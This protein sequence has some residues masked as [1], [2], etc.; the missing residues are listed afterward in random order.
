M[1]I[2]ITKV[3][4]ADG[5]LLPF[6]LA[7]AWATIDRVSGRSA[8]PSWSRGSAM[9]SLSTPTSPTAP[10]ARANGATGHSRARRLRS[11][12]VDPMRSPGREPASVP[13]WF[14]FSTYRTLGQPAPGESGR[15]GHR[16][17]LRSRWLGANEVVL[18]LND[19]PPSTCPVAGLISWE[20]DLLGDRYDRR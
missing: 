13:A 7:L 8:T 10:R 14:R 2:Q 1:I 4:N 9:T 20:G 17:T 19:V 6:P 11:P 15:P 3:T 18:R 16:R 12:R 5:C